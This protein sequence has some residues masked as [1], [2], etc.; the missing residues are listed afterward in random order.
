MD[1]NDSVDQVP[2]DIAK[3]R[4]HYDGKHTRK[5]YFYDN[6]NLVEWKSTVVKM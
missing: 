2:F 3:A 1:T 5:K 4:S 6:Y